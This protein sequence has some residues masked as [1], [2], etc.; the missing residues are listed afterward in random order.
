MGM[1]PHAVLKPFSRTHF[2]VRANRD[3]NSLAQWTVVARGVSS[4]QCTILVPNMVNFHES[5]LQ[6]GAVREVDGASVTIVADQLSQKHSGVEYAVELGSFVLVASPQSD[7]IATVSAIRMQEVVE[8]GTALERKVVICTLVGFLRDGVKFE[9]G[10]ERYPTVGSEAFL[11]TAG[12]LDSMFTPTGQTLEIGDRCQRGGGK[13]QILIDKMFGRHTAVLGTSGAGKSWTVAS[14]LQA[15][16]GRLSHTRIVFLDLHDE[17][18]SAFPENFQRIG[19]KVRH[20]SSGALRIPHWCLNAEE[21]EAL[22][23]SRESTAANQSALFKS[24]IKELRES[25]GKAAGLTGASISVDTPV[26]F[27]FQEL[28]KRIQDLNEEMVQGAKAGSERQGAWFGKLSNL[29]MRMESRFEDPRYRFLERHSS[30]MLKTWAGRCSRVIASAFDPMNPVFYH[31]SF[32]ISP[33]PPLTGNGLPPSNGHLAS[34][35]STSLNSSRWNFQFPLWTSSGK[36][37]RV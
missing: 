37:S 11:M 17:Y 21:L 18:R 15:A 22:F 20:I 16:M 19:R 23:A 26:F 24:V 5:D 35:T 2:I 10:I 12:A 27:S 36:S 32:S 6:F 30:T 31:S 13:E 9:R 28:L 14:I 8:K 29:L 1:Y 33:R 25:A 7:L 3:L 34:R 4:A